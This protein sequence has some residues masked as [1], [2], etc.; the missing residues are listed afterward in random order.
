MN[1]KAIKVFDLAKEMVD[2]LSTMSKKELK[3]LKL[4]YEVCFKYIELV[5]EKKKKTGDDK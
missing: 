2:I 4:Q 1:S 5:E 3:I